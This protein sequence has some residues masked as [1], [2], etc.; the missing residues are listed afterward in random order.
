MY[1]LTLKNL[2]IMK[3]KRDKNIVRCWCENYLDLGGEITLLLQGPLG[4]L[5]VVEDPVFHLPA[6]LLDLPHV[7]ETGGLEDPE[8]LELAPSVVD[9]L[10]LLLQVLGLL[11]LR[12]EVVHVHS[13]VVH[14]AG[15]QV[16]QLLGEVVPAVVE[17]LVTTDETVQ[18][19]LVLTD[20]VG[21]QTV[22]VSAWEADGIDVCQKLLT[23]GELQYLVPGSE[24]EITNN[25]MNGNSQL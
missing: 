10:Q 8:F 19:D 9:L 4:P 11:L 18:D 2:L 12:P 22:L 5:L 7:G 1:F 17:H 16:V 25:D 15:L 23:E 13:E 3:R 6:P 20:P 21:G 24:I 14:Q